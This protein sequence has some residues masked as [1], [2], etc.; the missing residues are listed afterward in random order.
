MNQQ[1]NMLI[2]KEKKNKKKKRR[3]K[4]KNHRNHFDYLKS[5]PF[6]G[7]STKNL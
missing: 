6:D 4:T 5:T 1:R 7:I 2:N 3:K